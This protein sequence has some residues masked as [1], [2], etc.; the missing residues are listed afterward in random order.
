M[1]SIVSG[2]GT[3]I[4]VPFIPSFHY[5]S[6]TCYLDEAGTAGCTDIS[7]STKLIGNTTGDASREFLKNF[8]KLGVL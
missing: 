4:D 1:F 6:L 7:N 8:L 2:S 3:N 5:F